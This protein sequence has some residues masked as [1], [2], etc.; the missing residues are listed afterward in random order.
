MMNFS[1][2]D[3]IKTKYYAGIG[4]R[5]T[6]DDIQ[7]FM[8]LSARVLEKKGLI[9]RS[10]GADGADKAFEDGVTSQ[11]MKEIYLPWVGFNNTP[12]IFMGSMM[13][14]A[15][16]IA[17]EYHPNWSRCSFGAKQLLTRN[18]FQ[19]LGKDLKTPSDF[20][21]CWT[22][23]GKASGGTGQALRIAKDYDIPIFNL[24][25]KDT[26]KNVAKTLQ[27]VFT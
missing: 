6:P 22:K 15:E 25:N 11:D 10:G 17:R 2:I 26:L 4:S 24:H 13:K 7:T 1:D 8:C 5:E 21:I 20:I 18:T 12:G 19:V 27:S 23:D 16:K 9:L 14:E 3:L